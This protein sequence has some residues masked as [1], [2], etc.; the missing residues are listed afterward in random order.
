M[1]NTLQAPG[2]GSKKTAWEVLQM[3]H[4]LICGVVP[5]R[6]IAHQSKMEGDD[7]GGDDDDDLA[8]G[9]MVLGSII[10][11]DLKAG[12]PLPL[13]SLPIEGSRSSEEEGVLPSSVLKLVTGQQSKLALFEAR[14]GE[15]VRAAVEERQA[16]EARLDAMGE[17]LA[18]IAEKLG[19]A[20]PGVEGALSLSQRWNPFDGIR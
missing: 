20:K 11:V 3:L 15:M 12:V 8:E 1:K 18:A 6:E 2:G 9:S 7:V 4:P 16:S 14:L 10:E 17:T 5:L 13:P 19:V